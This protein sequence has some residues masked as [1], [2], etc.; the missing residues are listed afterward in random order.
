MVRGGCHS[1]A[2]PSGSCMPTVAC[3]VAP[4]PT[5]RLLMAREFH[6]LY[7]DKRAFRARVGST[8]FL[9]GVVALVFFQSASWKD[10]DGNSVPSVIAQVNASFGVILQAGIVALFMTAQATIV[11]FPLE[12]PVFLRECV[13]LP[14]AG[15]PWIW[16]TVHLGLV[17]QVCRPH[18]LRVRV[19]AE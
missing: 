7:R 3:A 4:S 12:R 9:T 14:R 17:R 13:E 15:S 8:F 6:S 10:V 2:H 11:T 18:V 1:A 19:F 16:L 5:H